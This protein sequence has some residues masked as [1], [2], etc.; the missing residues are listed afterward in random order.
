[1][2]EQGRVSP[3][4]LLT[5][6]YGHEREHR[7]FLNRIFDEAAPFYNAINNLASM[8]SGRWY[9]LWALR[10]AGLLP[11][12]R[13]LDVAT[14]TG[15]VARPAGVLVGPSGMVAGLDPSLGMMAQ[16]RG[17]RHSTRLTQGVAD[18]LPFRDAVFDFL[19]MG[20][21]L[22]HVKDL[23]QTFHE[24]LRVLKPGGTLLVLDFC[25]PESPTAYHAV[26]FYLKTIV[27]RLVRFTAG[28]RAA[29]RLM[30]YCW[31]TVHACVPPA[32]ILERLRSADFAEISTE[33]FGMMIE[34]RARRRAN[35]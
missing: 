23:G 7:P 1:M 31:E 32:E 27:P 4:P 24:Y 35:S 9:R 28:G 19:S 15:A 13:V 8:G 16:Q 34:Y 2:S 12:M 33:R 25:R 26:R 14:G 22:R 18:R 17:K 5:N 21:A 10:R 6:W 30:E 11:G 29:Q 20:Y 3:H